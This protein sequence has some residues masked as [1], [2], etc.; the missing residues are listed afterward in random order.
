MNVLLPEEI[1]D[2]V[3]N[4]L[5]LNAE[6]LVQALPNLDVGA[7]LRRVRQNATDDAVQ[8]RS[9][10]LTYLH[11]RFANL[12][13]S[14]KGYTAKQA[15]DTLIQQFQ[16]DGCMDTMHPLLNWLRIT[17]TQL[18]KMIQVRLLHI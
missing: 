11:T 18:A 8:R 4:T 6:A 16:A 12:L 1:F 10:F 7:L 14:N 2:D 9:R 5:V 13:L 17:R 3:P 15:W